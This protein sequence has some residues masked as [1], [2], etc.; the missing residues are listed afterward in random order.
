MTLVRMNHELRDRKMP[1]NKLVK[2]I[3]GLSQVK[4]TTKTIWKRKEVKKYGSRLWKYTTW[5]K[6]Y[7]VY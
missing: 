2:M 3:T 1:M 6:I 4:Y 5:V 7:K